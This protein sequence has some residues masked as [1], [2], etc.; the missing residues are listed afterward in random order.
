[1]FEREEDPYFDLQHRVALMDS[2]GVTASVVSL[3]PFRP[4][5]VSHL[6]ARLAA[7]ANDGLLEAC[8]RQADRFVALAHL[9]L[10]DVEASLAELERIAGEPGLRGIS[11]VAAQ[12]L[13]R[14]DEIGIEPLLARA[15]EL[16]LPVVLHPTVSSVDFGPGF[17]GLGLESGMQAMVTTSLVASR[18]AFSGIL[19]RIPELEL[20]LTNLGGVLPF[21]GERLDTRQRGPARLPMTEYMRT[22]MYFD[23]CGYPAGVAFRCALDAVGPGRIL[24]GS[25]YPAR[26]I[27][28]HLESVRQLGLSVDEEAAILGGTAARWF[29]PMI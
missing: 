20:V 7:L 4:V 22:R 21:L 18:L 1:V 14:P 24:L 8:S 19:D 23:S 6:S 26:P 29:A 2:L 5:E 25:D 16:G 10:P 11:V 9:P 15:A 12:T 17:F 13:Y 3:M 28:P 27:E